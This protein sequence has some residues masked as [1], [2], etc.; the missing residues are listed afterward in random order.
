LSGNVNVKEEKE[1]IFKPVT[2]NGILHEININNLI[3]VVKFTASKNL[4]VKIRVFPHPTID[5]FAWK[6][7]DGKTQN[8]IGS[9]SIDWSL[10]AIILAVRLF[11]GA[12]IDADQYLAVEQHRVEVSNRFTALEDLNA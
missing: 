5:N 2:G 4:A 6:S 8:E 3:K 10:H 11:R 9:T 7:P 12:D 1:D